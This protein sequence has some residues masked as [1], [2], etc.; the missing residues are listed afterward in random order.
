MRLRTYLLRVN[1][2]PIVCVSP[3]CQSTDTTCFAVDARAIVEQ[4]RHAPISKTCFPCAR[5]AS[6][7]N[8]LHFIICEISCA[9]SQENVFPLTDVLVDRLGCC[10]LAGVTSALAS[11]SIVSHECFKSGAPPVG[12][13]SKES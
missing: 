13:R 11:E 5:S 12:F 6:R 10:F 8:S 3:R 2:Q 1:P 7:S 4:P 9:H